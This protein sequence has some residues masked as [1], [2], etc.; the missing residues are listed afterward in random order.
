MNTIPSFTSLFLLAFKREQ[1][2]EAWTENAGGEKVFIRSW[3]FTA[4]SGT[5]GPKLRE[6]DLQIPEGVYGVEYLNPNSRF[7]LSFKLTY[8]NAF[9]R[10]MAERDG[11]T[12]PG[13]DIFIHGGAQ[14]TGCI[15]IG[16]EAIEA[17]YAWVEQAG[18]ENVTVM[19]F[20]CDARNGGVFPSPH[21][22]PG[23]TEELYAMLYGELM[24]FD[25]RR[26]S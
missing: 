17:L 1:K 3:P 9:D 2:L 5:R 24:P 19:I 20:P 7:H 11:R 13:S 18:K 15:A 26:R 8:P 4:T 6:G 22:A 25:G 10:A 23:W 16:D 14:S 21:N 12:D